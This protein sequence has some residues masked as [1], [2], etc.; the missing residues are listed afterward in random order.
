MSRRFILALAAG[1]VVA[2]LLD[3]W[4]AALI[5]GVTLDVIMRA[6]ARGLL[7]AEAMQGGT[8]TAVLG[9]VLHVLMSLLI[10]AIYGAATLP[11]PVLLRRWV[12]F[13]VL[14]GLGVFVVMNYVV[15]PLSAIGRPPAFHSLAF[16][17][18]HVLAM[19]GFGLIIA[20]AAHRG[21][22]PARR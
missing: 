8:S 12:L 14:F 1:G 16:A 18:Q 4:A 6:V 2:G 9:L 5:N 7:G 21:A 20:Y 11:L 3:L 19:V 13:G 10:A 17:L 22:R 15:V